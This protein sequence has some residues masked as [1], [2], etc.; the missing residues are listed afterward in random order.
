M[1]EGKTSYGPAV[2]CNVCQSPQLVASFLSVIRGVEDGG[3]VEGMARRHA[4]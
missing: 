4:A 2:A 1:R 3:M